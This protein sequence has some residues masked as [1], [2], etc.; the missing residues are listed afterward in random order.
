MNSGVKIGVISSG[1]GENLRYIIKA[2][3]SGYL[4]AEVVIVLTDKKDAGAIRIAQ[5]Y[6][7]KYHFIDPSGL[8]HEE[9]DQALVNELDSHDISLVVLTGYMRIL[10]S[11]FVQHYPGRILNIHPAL[12]PSFR[13]LNAFQQALDYGVK[14]SGTTIHLV[15]DHIDH[16]PIIYQV[17]VPVKENDTYN[18]LKGRIQ[19]AEYKAYPKAIKM[20]IEGNP[21]IKGRRLVLDSNKEY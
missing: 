21:R 3:R 19:R 13:G 8:N 4:Q 16:G 15:D 6:G 5:E 1:R 17:P 18:S 9:Y 20:F 10:S 7:I 2:I 12:L 11:S 14:W